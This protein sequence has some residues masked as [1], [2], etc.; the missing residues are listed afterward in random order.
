MIKTKFFLTACARVAASLLPSA[1]CAEGAEFFLPSPACGRGAGVRV[2]AVVSFTLTTCLLALLPSLPARA[3]ALDELRSFLS[4]TKSARGQFE[5]STTSIDA[6]KKEGAAPKGQLTS[7]TFEFQR[8]GRFRWLYTKPYEQ[9]IVADGE[10]LYIYDKDLNQVTVKRLQGALPSSPASILFG[11][12][13]F[14]HDFDVTDD[15]TRDGLAW[16]L[17]KPKA[18]DTPFQQIQIGFK[19]GLPAAMR[20][21][22]SLGNLTVLSL[23]AIDRNPQLDPSEFKFAPPPGADVLEDR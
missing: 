6:A 12:N 9:L 8:P 23:K 5:Q 10:H 1:A 14:E 7:G 21:S 3:A 4:Q 13:D 11:T 2:R 20:L 22:D 19:D 17:A 15:G 16:I 18:K